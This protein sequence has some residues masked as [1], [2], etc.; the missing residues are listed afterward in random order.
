MDDI[1]RSGNS[2]LARKVSSNEVRTN[3]G[4]LANL[5]AAR[6]KRDGIEGRGHI[7][8]RMHLSLVH[9]ELFRS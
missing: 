8:L 2:P 9:S 6:T 4:N 3:L 7:E 5:A 1:V